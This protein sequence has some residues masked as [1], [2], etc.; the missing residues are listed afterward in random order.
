[1]KKVLSLGLV[2][3]LVLLSS[4]TKTTEVKA[5]P[6]GKEGHWVPMGNGG[7]LCAT[8]WW[9]NQCMVGDTRPPGSL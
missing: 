2:L 7:Y 3:V 1:M 8:H 4:G 5:G 6:F 9:Q